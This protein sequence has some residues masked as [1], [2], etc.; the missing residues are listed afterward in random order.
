MAKE[1]PMA[2]AVFKVGGEGH[3]G[4]YEATVTATLEKS[5]A[6]AYGNGTC[7]VFEWSDRKQPDLFDTRY[8]SV[9]S[10]NFTEF[11][12]AEL[13]AR[14]LDSIEIETIEG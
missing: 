10:K 3:N 1:Q 11:A 2:K 9:S 4:H 13:R 12:K 5:G 7:M 14:L 6:F 8:C